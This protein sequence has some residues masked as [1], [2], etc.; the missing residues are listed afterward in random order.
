MKKGQ[1]FQKAIKKYI[2]ERVFFWDLQFQTKENPE[3]YVIITRF[4]NGSFTKEYRR[5]NYEPT[6]IFDALKGDP[7][8]YQIY[9]KM[10]NMSS[11]DAFLLAR[12]LTK[13]RTNLH[14]KINHKLKE[15]S[16][17]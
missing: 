4:V 8:F 5:A 13:N 1:K 11:G 14:I 2:N 17:F 9:S 12:E 10:Q 15:L 6:I 7:N 3:D 16:K